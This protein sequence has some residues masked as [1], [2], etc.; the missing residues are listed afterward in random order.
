MDSCDTPQRG[1]YERVVKCSL[2]VLLMCAALVGGCSGSGS[3]KEGK[4]SSTARSSAT[5][6]STATTRSP[7]ERSLLEAFCRVRVGQLK[8]SV[9]AA[10]GPPNGHIFDSYK[11]G[12]GPGVEA[13]EWDNGRV[14]FLVTFKNARVIRF[15]GSSK[16]GGAT[17]CPIVP[18]P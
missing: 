8:Q 10:M 16:D 13:L 1:Q 5:D 7:D 3:S 18:H 9:V 12:L 15:Q 2:V 4:T 11:R 6:S 17:A 14:V